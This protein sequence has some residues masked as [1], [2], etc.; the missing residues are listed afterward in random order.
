GAEP[1]PETT[2]LR[3]IKTANMCWAPQYVAEEFLKAEGF[4]EVTYVEMRVG[5]PVSNL[6]T[7]GDADISMN[8]V[9]PNLIRVDQGAPVVFLAGVHV[10]CFEMFGGGR[11]R[12]ISDLKGKTVSVTALNGTEHVFVASIASYVGLDPRKDINWVIHDADEGLTLFA[13]GK[14]DAYIGFPP[15][16][17]ELRARGIGHVIVNSAVDRPWSQYFCCLM[18][19]SRDFV[20]KHPMTPNPPLPPIL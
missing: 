2:K 17:Q 3:L 20:R 15:R 16:P 5:V 11:V 6:L 14:V 12:K 18:T 9:G 4:T 1:P 7:A 10:G 8:F 13:D 19:G